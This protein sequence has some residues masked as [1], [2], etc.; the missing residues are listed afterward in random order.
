[1][2]VAQPGNLAV[3]GSTGSIG[4]QTL[5]LVRSDPGQFKV[6]SLAAKSNTERLIKQAREF[7]PQYVA[8]ADEKA[9]YDVAEELTG[10]G[11]TVGIGEDAV[12]EAAKLPD[13]HTVVAAVIGF[14][15]L[16]SV[17]EALRSDKHVALA[18]K[19]SLVAGGD[20]VTEALSASKGLLV[21]VDSEH[22]SIFQ[23]LETVHAE[24]EIRKIVLTASGG[25]FLKLPLEK[26]ATITPEDAVNHPTWSMGAKISVDSATMMNKGLE[27]LEA[28]RLFGLEAEKIDILVHPQS[29]MHGYVEFE[30]GTTIAALYETDMRIPI[31][32]ALN[33]LYSDNPLANPGR[34]KKYGTTSYLDL[35]KHKTLEFFTPDL[36]RFP[37]IGLC[38]EALRI[39]GSMPIVLNAANEIA[40]EAFMGG[41]IKFLDIT[42]VIEET[43]R[44][45]E[46]VEVVNFDSVLRIDAE[47]RTVASGYCVQAKEED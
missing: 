10:E 19:E 42:R 33:F 13:V 15:G 38:Y 3:I 36:S 18:N 5:E 41:R 37:A 17:L 24:E 14:S 25:P 34:R 39:G 32:H 9:G 26:F 4:R 28:S 23:C 43:M 40:V 8:V 47:A 6:I 31:S 46:Q 30:D 29:I 16:R 1:M 44:A 27:V 21:P 7:L 35:A 45:H 11:I 22:N 12:A 20:L 2:M